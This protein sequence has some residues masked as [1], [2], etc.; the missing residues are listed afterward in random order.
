MNL[1]KIEARTDIKFKVNP[2]RK[3]GEYIDPKELMG[4]MLPQISDLKMGDTFEGG[5]NQC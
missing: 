3:N 1:A 2:K 5:L 4:I